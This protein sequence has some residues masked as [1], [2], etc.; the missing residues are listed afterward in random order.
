MPMIEDHVDEFLRHKLGKEMPCLS[1][2]IGD[3]T[4]KHSKWIFMQ[5]LEDAFPSTHEK[6]C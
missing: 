4:I 6:L 1:L 3:K 5:E 2:F